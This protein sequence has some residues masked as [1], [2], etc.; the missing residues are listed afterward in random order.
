MVT[1]L[2]LPICVLLTA[3]GTLLPSILMRS[4]VL[5]VRIVRCLETA[6][7]TDLLAVW[8]LLTERWSALGRLLLA[9]WLLA[10]WGVLRGVYGQLSYVKD[11]NDSPP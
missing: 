8:W 5:L 4:S 2:L 3:K 9:V 7:W 6:V 11:E 10:V 1:H